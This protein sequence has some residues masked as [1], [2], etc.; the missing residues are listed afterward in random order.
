MDPDQIKKL[1]DKFF[2]G[3]ITRRERGILYNHFKKI[4]CRDGQIY[5]DIIG[6]FLFV[7]HSDYGKPDKDGIIRII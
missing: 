7:T 5:E 6:D 4:V 2:Y 3:T 1:H